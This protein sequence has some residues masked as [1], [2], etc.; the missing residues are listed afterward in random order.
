MTVQVADDGTPVLTD[1]ETI[2]ITVNPI[3]DAPI[4]DPIGDKTGD[5]DTLITFDANATDPDGID[6]LTYTL[7]A[8]APPPPASTQPP[9]SSP[10]RPAKRTALASIR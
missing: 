4:L 10:G 5:E 7:A 6:T 3:N 8:G 9:A 2:S 1:T